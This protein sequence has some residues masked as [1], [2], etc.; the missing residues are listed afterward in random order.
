MPAPTAS[1]L[2]G[3]ANG[4]LQSAGIR[5]QDAPGLAAALASA[6][7]QA[8]SLF[9]NQAMV[10]PGIPAT[11]PPPSGSGSTTGPGQLLPPPAGGP[12]AQQLEG[13][14][15]AALTAQN[16][17]G[18]KAGALAQVIAAS[19]AQA[20]VLFTAQVQV[21]P[22]ITISGFSTTSPGSLL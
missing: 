9:L 18:E 1:Q 19:I 12:T 21:A 16:L 7:A 4:A 11:A 17:Q 8:L 22:G 3:I 14:A 13:F 10:L 20:L 15:R 2:E 5:G 6:I